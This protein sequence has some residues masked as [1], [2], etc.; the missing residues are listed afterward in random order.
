MQDIHMEE[1]KISVI[2]PAYN[3][4]AYISDCLNSILGNRYRNLEIICIDDGSTD[5]T[6]GILDEFAE[7]DARIVVVR[8]KNAGVSAA[9]NAGLDIATGDFIAF[10]DSDDF[11]DKDFF[12]KLMQCMQ[13]T[14]A[15]IVIGKNREVGEQR[16]EAICSD[17]YSPKLLGLDEVISNAD[18]KNHLWGRIY[19][20]AAIADNRMSTDISLGED[21]VFNLAVIF[22]LEQPVICFVDA[23][24][25]YYR[26]RTSS[27]IHT[28][29]N[30]NMLQMVP[31]LLGLLDVQSNEHKKGL[32][33]KESFKVIYA[34]RYLEQFSIEKRYV[35]KLSKELLR[36]CT[37]EIYGIRDIPLREKIIY[38]LMAKFSALYRSYRIKQDRTTLQWE[39]AEKERQK[40]KNKCV[41]R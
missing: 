38:I 30:V 8:Q 16:H 3:T 24:L 14:S 19:T 12:S 4:A 32:L 15:D 5:A 40:M 35:R 25:Y 22:S 1:K 18:A 31:K 29:A 17:G 34:Y 13:E 23:R 21:T 7:R 26:K 20:K 36:K 9:R 41:K 2:I 6:A 10:V 11:V 27:A 33:L 37:A 28:M 39:K